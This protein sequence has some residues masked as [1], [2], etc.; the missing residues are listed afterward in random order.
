MSQV[1]TSKKFDVLIVGSGAGGGAVASRLAALTRQ[2][3]RVGMLE[4]GP[5][6]EARHNT[7]DEVDMASRYYYSLGAFQTSSQDVALAFANV[8]GGSTAVY[9]G[10]SLRA[11]AHVFERWGV[12]GISRAELDPRY[13]N[14]ERQNGVHFT[15]PDRINLN[16]QFFK[17]GCEKLGWHLEQ[18][19][20]NTRGCRG[21]AVCNLGC[22]GGAKQGTARVQI[23][24]AEQ[25]GL[26]VFPH[27]R[28]LRISGNK[29]V[30]RVA[31]PPPPI[32][33]ATQSARSLSGM[34]DTQVPV[35]PWSPGV[36]ELTA[37]K[38]VVAAGAVHSP[39]LLQRSLGREKLPALGA[40]FTCHPAL[41]LAGR[42]AQPLD[43]LSGHPKCY[44]SEEFA[45]SERFLL[46][47]CMYYPFTLSKNLAGFGP[48]LDRMM[49]R[50][51]HLQM[52][53][54]L[55]IDDALAHNRVESKGDD[56][57]VVHYKLTEKTIQS[58]T[59]S[60]R[61][62]A[63]IFFAAGAEEVHAPAG[64]TFTI[65][66]KDASRVDE[67]IERKYFKRGKL[68]V[69]AAHLMGGCRMGDNPR[70][71]VTDSWGK[72]HGYDHIYV[73][74]ASLFP[75]AAEINPYLTVMALADRVGEGI[76]RTM[77]VAL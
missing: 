63:K 60:M 67:L 70:S 8:V 49:N 73:A 4:S 19:P 44:Y 30:I 40:Y 72:V 41:I 37:E 25:Q 66:R 65:S 39:A 9:T 52:I 18:F 11:P 1:P 47:S 76:L 32:S 33:L 62:A 61:A 56:D 16:N 59:A 28:V 27:C 5:R 21:R 58:L 13:E 57:A 35:P 42:H 54:A 20:V 74:D 38:I 53:L 69:S 15:P 77:G 71:S 45:A 48:D 3:A 50:M 43:S 64:K 68:S 6:Y 22:P 34:G 7:G 75:A 46:E 2:G 14:F 24:Q 55:A 29:V 17:A 10:T 26:E 12:P 31:P 23:P 36:H 51:T